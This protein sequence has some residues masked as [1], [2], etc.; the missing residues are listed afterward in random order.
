MRYDTNP[1]TII[2]RKTMHKPKNKDEFYQNIT[3]KIIA[4]LEKVSLEDYQPPF[5]SLA[6]QGLP[7]N[8]FT[9]KHYQGINIPCLWFYQQEKGFN[10]NQW[11][12][13]KQWKEKGVS[14]RKGEKGSTI[15]FYKTLLV[16]E[17][18][19][20]GEETTHKIPMMKLYTVFNAV[21]VEGYDNVQQPSLNETDL[22]VPVKLPD[23]FCKS[24]KADIRHLN[25][26]AA[27]YHRIEDYI[28]LPETIN[29]VNTEDS[30]ATE[31][32]YSTLFHELVHWSGAP[33]RLDRDKA[34]TNAE[35]FKYAFEELVAEL[36]AAM[37]CA[38]LGISQQP[39]A[40]HAQY[41]KSWLQALKNDNKFVFQAAAHSARAVEYLNQ[42]QPN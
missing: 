16:D 22:V 23:N 12:T 29:F 7:V 33:H 28:C 41:I 24:T 13:F 32:Y 2:W 26:S 40:D 3:N 6:A 34:K 25:K 17:E 1:K 19:E 27:Y 5:A 14:V 30:T 18:N 15:C 38:Q 36:G 37:L 42:L 8:P 35:K 39:R 11:A 10:S 21:Q 9:E 4:Q 31:N 20:Q